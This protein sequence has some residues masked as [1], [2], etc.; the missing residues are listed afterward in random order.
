MYLFVVNEMRSFSLA[1]RD[2]CMPLYPGQAFISH[3]EFKCL[4][5]S[6]SLHA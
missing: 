1:E 5:R 3:C 2:C 4:Q 6:F